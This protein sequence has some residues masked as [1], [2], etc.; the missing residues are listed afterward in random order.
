MKFKFLQSLCGSSRT[1]PTGRRRRRRQVSEASS[2][3]VTSVTSES[4]GSFFLVN[5]EIEQNFSRKKKNSARIIHSSHLHR[6]FFWGVGGG[7]F[8][9]GIESLPPG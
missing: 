2:M 9:E 5:Q 4:S 1:P 8:R 7:E 3:S 6:R